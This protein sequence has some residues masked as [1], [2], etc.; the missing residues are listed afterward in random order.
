M[1][2]EFTPQQVVKA[3]VDYGFDD[4]RRDLRLEVQANLPDTDA[5]QAQATYDLLFDLCYWLATGRQLDAFVAEHAH[6]PPTCDFLREVTPAMA[7]NGEMLGAI[8]QRML[9]D[10]VE[11]GVAWEEG[12]GNVHRAVQQMTA[13]GMPH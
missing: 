1:E 10:E 4:F 8:L 11:R 5:E 7:P 3:E 2:W 12:L 9:M 6:S 13:A